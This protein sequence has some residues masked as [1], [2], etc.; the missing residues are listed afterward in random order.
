MFILT[1]NPDKVR[2]IEHLKILGLGE[3]FR[4]FYGSLEIFENLRNL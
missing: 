1:P 3:I 2:Q 4:D